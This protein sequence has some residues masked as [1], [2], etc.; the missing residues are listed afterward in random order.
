MELTVRLSAKDMNTVGVFAALE[1]L[2]R[3]FKPE[4]FGSVTMDPDKSKTNTEPVNKETGGSTAG[5]Q[6]PT[7]PPAPHQQPEAIPTPTAQ[8]PPTEIPIPTAPVQNTAPP[9]VPVAE[10]QQ[11]TKPQ[12][13]QAAAVYA[14]TSDTARQQV[15]DLIHGYGV[16]ALGDIPQDKLGEFATRLRGLGARI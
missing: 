12:I 15:C 1:E 7:A 3:C 10:P 5:A 6:P 9:V 14:E 2:C 13:A 8:Q 4:E 16:A 11:F